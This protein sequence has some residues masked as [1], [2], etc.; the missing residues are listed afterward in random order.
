MLL[1]DLAASRSSFD[2]KMLSRSNELTYDVQ[3]RLVDST[4][5]D[6]PIDGDFGPQSK[7]ALQRFAAAAGLEPPKTALT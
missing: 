1:E 3:R 7:L 2:L 5:L 4:L 6:P